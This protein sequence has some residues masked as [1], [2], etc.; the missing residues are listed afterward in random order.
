MLARSD[1]D[2]ALFYTAPEAVS[3]AG[4]SSSSPSSSAKDLE[5]GGG[6]DEP[7]GTTTV[8]IR[9][10]RELGMAHGRPDVTAVITE[11]AREASAEDGAGGR[12]AFFVCGPGGMADEARAAVQKALKA[13]LGSVEYFE[14][15]FGW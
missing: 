5:L 4:D 1:F 7:K 15:S 13:G 8:A 2:A 11:A 9:L 14:E 6:V 10:A 12:T 3:G